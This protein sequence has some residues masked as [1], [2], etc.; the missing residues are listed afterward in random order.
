MNFLNKKSARAEELPRCHEYMYLAQ[1]KADGFMG[2]KSVKNGCVLNLYCMV[3]L[4][5]VCFSARVVN[6]FS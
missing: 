3:V 6:C 5:G 2:P 4:C 1:E